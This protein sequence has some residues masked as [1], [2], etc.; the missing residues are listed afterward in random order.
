MK[1]IRESLRHHSGF[2]MIELLTVILVI[3]IL[4]ALLL[5]AVQQAREAARATTCKNNLQQIG[6][7]LQNYQMA[8]RVL[9]SGTV[10]KKRLCQY[11]P[12]IV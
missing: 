6:L 8:H 10:F 7:A 9:P 4:I 3:A 2:V 12:I 5:P 11:K 1:L